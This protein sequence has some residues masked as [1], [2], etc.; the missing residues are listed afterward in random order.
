MELKRSVTSSDAARA[1]SAAHRL[2]SNAH[3]IGAKVL[4]ELCARIELH[5]A[6][7]S[8]AELSELVR[9]MEAEAIRVDVYLDSLTPSQE[10]AVAS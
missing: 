7:P 4:G 10:Q 9:T 5:G 3:S 2:K 8:S 6:A 1:A